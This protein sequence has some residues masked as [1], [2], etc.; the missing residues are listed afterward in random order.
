[1]TPYSGTQIWTT[2]KPSR[3]CRFWQNAL[4]R[5]EVENEAWLGFEDH[6]MGSADK[7]FPLLRFKEHRWL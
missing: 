5:K 2:W 3:H 1:M 4:G 6:G 7:S